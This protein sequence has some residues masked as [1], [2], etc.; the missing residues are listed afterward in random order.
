MEV[1]LY[2]AKYAPDLTDA[3]IFPGDPC[4]HVPAFWAYADEPATNASTVKVGPD[5]LRSMVSLLLKVPSDHPAIFWFATF[6][7]IGV[8]CAASEYA[9]PLFNLA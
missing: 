3:P 7:A 1:L 2:D 8:P 9:G 5:A 6:G 4:V